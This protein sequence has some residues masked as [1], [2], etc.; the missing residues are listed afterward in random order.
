MAT[1]MSEEDRRF[2][3]P[4][5]GHAEDM[6]DAGTDFFIEPAEEQLP[7]GD[8]LETLNQLAS[9]LREVQFEIGGIE[10]N[11]ENAIE[12]ERKIRE[13]S[14]PELMKE[15]G[16]K[17]LTLA[18]GTKLIVEP[19]FKCG[20]SEA[21]KPLAFKWLRD[22]SLGGIIKRVIGVAFGK[23]D[24]DAAKKLREQLT[25]DGYIVEDDE[26]VHWQTL[27]A[28]LK[29]EREKGTA[30]PQDLFS[31]FEYQTT[32]L[33]PPRGVPVPPKQRYARKK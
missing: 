21:S 20:I 25:K 11:L 16:M 26:G 10:T 14:I 9:Q 1:E 18:D 29:E 19:D 2:G 13:E 6:P 5:Y 17:E 30:I 23:G 3:Q 33:K 27:K 28:T 24:D 12:R 22:N 15:V 8:R 7:T 4:H 31:L 32:K